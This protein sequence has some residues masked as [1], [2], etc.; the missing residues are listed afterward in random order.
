MWGRAGLSHLPGG[1]AEEGGSHVGSELISPGTPA[2]LF[3]GRFP[4]E[5]RGQM[6]LGAV[7]AKLTSRIWYNTGCG[8]VGVH[9]GR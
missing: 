4:V 5:D 9:I 3:L 6:F 2:V 1:A 8:K 7:P